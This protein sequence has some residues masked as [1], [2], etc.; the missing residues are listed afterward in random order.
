M[1]VRASAYESAIMCARESMHSN[2]LFPL[3][4]G[5]PGGGYLPHTQKGLQFSLLWFDSS[6]GRKEE[7]GGKKGVGKD[8]R[9]REGRP[10]KNENERK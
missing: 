6:L 9:E 5:A 1:C 3:L 10:G 4:Q 8:E 7:T 2:Q